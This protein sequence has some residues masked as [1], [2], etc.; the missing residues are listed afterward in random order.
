MGGHI[1]TSP[2]LSKNALKSSLPDYFLSLPLVFVVKI[3]FL[4]IKELSFQILSYVD[5]VTL[6]RVGMQSKTNVVLTVTACVNRVLQLV[7]S[8]DSIWKILHQTNFNE[9][10]SHYFIDRK[11]FSF[12]YLYKETKLI[13]RRYL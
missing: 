2:K 7:S 8:D 10:Y 9:T 1:S 11:F 3:N 6:C 5:Y 13:E 4:I 12:K